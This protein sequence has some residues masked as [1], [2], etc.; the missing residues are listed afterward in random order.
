[1]DTDRMIRL[2][3]EQARPP[4]A[5]WRR[6]HEAR[7]GHWWAMA[8]GLL[9]EVAIQGKTQGRGAVGPPDFPPPRSSPDLSTRSCRTC[10]RLRDVSALTDPVGEVTGMWTRPNGSSRPMRIPLGSSGL[11]M[12]PAQRDHDAAALCPNPQ[13]R[14]P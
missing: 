1:M 10:R 9:P 13:R 7:T 4:P 5:K 11:F 2:M 14:Y 12:N 6:E 3:A 8:D